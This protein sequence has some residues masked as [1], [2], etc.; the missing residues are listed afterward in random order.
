MIESD[1]AD[2]ILEEQT[3][4]YRVR[5]LNPDDWF[6]RRGTYDHGPTRN[7]DWFR[8]AVELMQ[9]LSGFNPKGHVLEI[10]GGTGLW[11]RQLVLTADHVT[12]VDVSE[13]SLALN[14]IRLGS[15]ASRVRYVERDIFS[16][17]A[18]ERFDAIFS[19]FFLS[20][21]PRHRFEQFWEFL[22]SILVP[23]GRIFWVDT[24]R[25]QTALGQNGRLPDRGS[26]ITRRRTGDREY[27]VYKVYYTP[28]SLAHQVGA[29]GW[30]AD[31]ASTQEFF[32]YG[33]ARRK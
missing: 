18:G 16:W 31:V 2:P 12:V 3:R 6:Y 33:S 11:T 21:V 8:D 19:P 4:Y 25:S 29:L 14:R 1:A 5:D 26:I 24:T 9:A 32:L 22:D 17:P 23:G 7:R 27:R 15:L 13:R 10:G 30:V 20:H 28:E